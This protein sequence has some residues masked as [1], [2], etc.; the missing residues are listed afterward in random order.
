[1]ATAAL[2][3]PGRNPTVARTPRPAAR[4]ARAALS[5]TLLLALAPVPTAAQRTF[6]PLN[7]SVRVFVDEEGSL[8]F[9]MRNDAGE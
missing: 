6:P 9:V 2:R 5:A 1:M 3:M 4:W 8:P 7:R